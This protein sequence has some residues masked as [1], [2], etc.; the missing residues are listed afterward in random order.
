MSSTIKV[1]Y[2]HMT[3]RAETTRLCLYIGGIPFDD[4]RMTGEE[5]GKKKAEGFWKFG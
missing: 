2:F 1:Y 5:F 4:V 3:G